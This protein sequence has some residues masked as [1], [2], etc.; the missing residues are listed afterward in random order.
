MAFFCRATLVASCVLFIGTLA[1][2]A[3]LYPYPALLVAGICGWKWLRRGR[4]AGWV[5]GTARLS[6]W[7]DVLHRNLGGENGLILGTSL[8]IALSA[9]S[10]E[11]NSPTVPSGGE[12][13]TVH[14][15]LVVSTPAAEGI[16]NDAIE[17]LVSDASA[18]GSEALVV[19]R[20][21]KIVYESYF[22]RR[23]EPIMAMSAALN[24]CW[25]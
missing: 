12:S 8:I 18:Q 25:W 20:N 3:A 9:C 5:H 4:P 15:G 17:R 24:T 23:D 7:G 19:L 22:G 6:G 10:S 13:P 14:D 2:L 16:A 21:G 1:A 11:A